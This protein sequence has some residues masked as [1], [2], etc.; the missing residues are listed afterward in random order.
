MNINLIFLI[1][2]LFHLIPQLTGTADK[3]GSLVQLREV[4]SHDA[5]IPIA[6]SAPCLL[7]DNSPMELNKVESSPLT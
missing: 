4:Q 7:C 3:K 1:K 2:Q 6:A 5:Q